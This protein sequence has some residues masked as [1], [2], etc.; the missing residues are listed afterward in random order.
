MDV[1][2]HSKRFGGLAVACGE[3][4]A[5]GEHGRVQP[6]QDVIVQ[7]PAGAA[8]EHLAFGQPL[9]LERGQPPRHL[10]FGLVVEQSLSRRSRYL[11]LFLRVGPAVAPVA[12]QQ[13]A[14]QPAFAPE[15]H[16]PP[17]AAC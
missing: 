1:A 7:D 16:S 4:G 6:W 17:G 13:G 8:V 5:Q 3:C 9:P 10:C 2:Q 15:G 11:D 12:Q 14:D